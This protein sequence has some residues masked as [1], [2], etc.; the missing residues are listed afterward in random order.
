MKHRFPSTWNM[1]DLLKHLGNIPARR[2]RLKPAPGTAT[3]RHVAEIERRENRLYELVDGVLVEKIMGLS[4]SAIA[5]ELGRVLGNFLAE[6]DL[7]FPS[8]ADGPVR[9][10]PGLVRIPDLAYIS[11]EQLP[12]REIPSQPIPNLVPDL[13]AEVLSEGNTREEMER[14]LKEYFLSG[15]KL[16][17]FVYLNTRTV[18]V[19][20]APDQST[21]LRGSQFLEGGEVLPGFRVAI[22]A[23]FRR[24]PPPGKPVAKRRKS[25]R[26]DSPERRHKQP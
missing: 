25:H 20:T 16:V 14:K 10:M 22:D 2:I 1:E 4:E 11:W 12:R 5:L 13:A 19:F 21:T 15:V 26:K 8:G 7:G 23:I 3:E 18:E 6:H 17:W 9:L 24:L